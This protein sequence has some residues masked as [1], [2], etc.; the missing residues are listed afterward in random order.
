MKIHRTICP[1]KGVRTLRET[2]LAVG[3][4]SH[5]IGLGPAQP[6]TLIS[7]AWPLRQISGLTEYCDWKYQEKIDEQEL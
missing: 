2:R 1:S 4:F 7:I 3:R 5:K 6:T